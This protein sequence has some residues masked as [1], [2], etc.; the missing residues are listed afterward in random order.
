MV[1]NK[2]ASKIQ[3]LF[4]SHIFLFLRRS[5]ASTFVPIIH[6]NNQVKK[7]VDTIYFN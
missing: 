2:K 7:L 4:V 6:R 3:K 1:I 5:L